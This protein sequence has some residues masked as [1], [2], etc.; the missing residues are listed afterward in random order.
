MKELAELTYSNTK[1]RDQRRRSIQLARQS[2]ADAAKERK[3]KID[4]LKANG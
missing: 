4:N 2:L 1:A 3:R